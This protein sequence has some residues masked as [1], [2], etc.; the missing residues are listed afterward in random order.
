[1]TILKKIQ[2]ELYSFADKKIAAHS[3]R[4]FKTGKEEYGEGDIFLGIRVPQ[5]RAVAKRHRT[6]DPSVITDLVQ[7]KYHEERMLGLI[8]LVERYKKV[9]VKERSNCYETYMNLRPHI[10]NWDLVDCSAPH[11]VGHYLYNRDKT[12]LFLLAESENLW[13]RRIAVI[14]TFYFIKQ[15]SFAV[16]LAISEILLQDDHDLIHKAVGWMLREVGK[17]DLTTQKDFLSSH[18]KKM[19]RTMLRYAIEK[20]EENERQQ[21]LHGT[22]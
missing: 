7:S 1:M 14:A 9:S 3:Q 6:V 2:E 18:Y 19:P 22:I 21:Y 4:F 10:N 12:I 5:V 15:H 16:T 8:M 20:F 13:E 17:R 11:I